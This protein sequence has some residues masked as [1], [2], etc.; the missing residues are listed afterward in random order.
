MVICVIQKFQEAEKIFIP[1]NDVGDE[2]QNLKNF[3]VKNFQIPDNDLKR[4]INFINEDEELEKLILN[5]PALIQSEVSYDK[6]EMKFYEEFQY[7]EL[8]LE[9]T[10]FTSNLDIE[11]CLKKEDELIHKLYDQYN[12]QSSDKILIFIE[13][14]K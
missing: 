8:I 12:E 5:V 7:D 2:T 9:V 1:S 13:V 14:V 6:L 3:I 4:I 11:N 10:A